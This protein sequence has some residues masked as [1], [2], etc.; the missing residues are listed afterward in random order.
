MRYAMGNLYPL[1]GFESLK[2]KEIWGIFSLAIYLL[3][4]TASEGIYI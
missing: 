3:I 2:A 1:I 4:A